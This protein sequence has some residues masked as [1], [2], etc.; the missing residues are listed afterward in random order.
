[1]TR[2][3]PE[4]PRLAR[5][6]LQLVLHP[7][8]RAEVLADVAEEFAARRSRDG[9][10]RARAWL[11]GQVWHSAPALLQRSWFRGR[12]GFESEADRMSEGRRGLEGWIVDM[13]FALRTLRT[14]PQYAVLAV[15]T[16]ALGIGGTTVLF[17]IARALLLNPLPY[18][19]TGE[20]VHLWNAFDWSEAEMVHLG[21]DWA[22]FERIAAYTRDDVFMRPEGGVAQLLPGIAANADLFDVLGTRPLLGSGFAAD[23][24][25][26]GAEPTVVLSY[27]LW[28]DLGARRD[29]VGTT[30]RLDGQPRRVV[31]VMP[32]GFWFPDPAVRVW[33]STPMRPDNGAGNYALVGRME[34]GRSIPTMADALQRV[35][36]RL[37]E[38]FTYSAQW[39]KTKNAELTSLREYLLGPVR[40]AI[41]AALA[42]MGV[43]L[44]MAC[45]NVATLM[46]GQLR[47]RSSE[48]AVRI[49]L[50]A[51]RSRLAQQLLIEACVLAVI[52]GVVGAIVAIAGFRVVLASLPLGEL[53]RAVHADWTLF[54]SALAISF[55]TALLIALAPLFSL[56][57]GD[58]RDAL[59]RVR[60]GGIGGRSRIE[61]GLVITE[62]AL[63]VLLAAGAAMLIRSVANLNAIDPGVA[64]RGVGIVDITAS[65]DMNDEQ[66]RQQVVQ[67]IESLRGMPGV[68][69][70][71]AVQ[72][73]PLRDRGDNWGIQIQ[74]QPELEA[75]TTALRVVSRDYFDVMGI[76]VVSGR[77]FDATD[78]PGGDLAIV[79]DEVLAR[80]YFPG[81]D[82]IG[83]LIAS[84]IGQGWMRVVGVVRGVA[85][86]GLTAETIPGRY[87]L[88]D[89][90]NYTPE[91]FSLVLRVERGRNAAGVLEQAVRRVQEVAANVA[92]REATT[93]ENVHALAMGPT[94][95]IMQ[96]MTL[97]GSLALT[98]GA[99]GVYGVVS[100]FVNRRRRDWI[101][102]MALGMNPADALTQVVR[103]GALLVTIGCVIGVA[104]ALLATRAL[105]SLLY[106]VGSADPLAIAAAV[107]ALIM[108]GCIAA[109]I[110][111]LRASRANPAQV[112]RDT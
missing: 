23:A 88:V 106:T 109:V 47:G 97:L 99:I 95:R 101:I 2:S 60:S 30:L 83:Q 8:E 7:A 68:T 41:L 78:V 104:A 75:T 32:A 71:A 76:P 10:A 84:S 102:R 15:L 62:V 92:I 20:L 110:P 34:A 111:G 87:V 96:L 13:R 93:M 61:E 103:R 105:A 11:W 66:R 112:L 82:P 24:D 38:R 21:D 6:L 56:W 58:L 74:S 65:G 31:G 16:L 107:A 57:R 22:G 18:R 40:P 44:L 91:G 51:G 77:T 4:L 90:F 86:D 33:L 39:D 70:V 64:T 9:G 45:A 108:T 26:V 72:R 42:G 100:H 35:T 50:G 53:S 80:K 43:I 85:H 73:L 54:V 27:G 28:Q 69:N 12:T 25:V 67:L 17:G 46:L 36:Q 55:V 98:L 3:Q 37:S 63:A 29:I 5:A 79:I 1:M 52:A 48:L 14:R 94:R 19:D 49:S 81:T 89:Q 59:Q